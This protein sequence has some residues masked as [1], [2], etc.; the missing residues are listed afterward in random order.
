MLFLSVPLTL[1]AGRLLPREI[2]RFW[3]QGP[4][5]MY[6]IARTVAAQR[7]LDAWDSARLLGLT[8]LV[9]ADSYRQLYPAYADGEGGRR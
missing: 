8:S 6:Q 4:S 1:I 7:N 9:L 3:F 2:A 5:S